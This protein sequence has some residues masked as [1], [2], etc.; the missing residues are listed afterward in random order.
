M[1]ASISERSCKELEE[2]KLVLE[3]GGSSCWW[4]MES[5]LDAGDTWSEELV[6]EV[7]SNVAES[8]FGPWLWLSQS[9]E[10]SLELWLT[11]EV[12]GWR[13]LAKVSWELP[14][15]CFLLGGSGGATSGLRR[16]QSLG[17]QNQK[18]AP[19]TLSTIGKLS[20]LTTQKTEKLL[21]LP[22]LFVDDNHK[23]TLSNYGIV[24]F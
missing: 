24:S 11:G 15:R 3:A 16:K 5:K 21:I 17:N 6:I 9:E 22:S 7:L 19:L 18:L 20:K 13:W 23:C 12:M 1:S 2:S 8:E 10:F 4:F 14:L